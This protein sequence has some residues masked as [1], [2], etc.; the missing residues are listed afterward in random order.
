M[1]DPF[2]PKAGT[3][4]LFPNPKKVEDWQADFSGT[5]VLPEDIQPNQSYW[6]YVTNK[7]NSQ[8]KSF[9]KVALGNVFIPKTQEP[10]KGVEQVVDEDVPF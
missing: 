6:L 5:I 9:V 10:A 1:A 3:A 8:G 4:Y 2:I 7:V